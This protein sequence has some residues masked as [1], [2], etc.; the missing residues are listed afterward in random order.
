M[1]QILYFIS[2]LACVA[3]AVAG[4]AEAIS[5]PWRHYVS[6]VGIVG[7]AVSAFMLQHPWSGHERRRPQRAISITKT[8]EEHEGHTDGR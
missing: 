5:E 7:T 8:Y 6:I 1:A 4:Q 3:T 2:M